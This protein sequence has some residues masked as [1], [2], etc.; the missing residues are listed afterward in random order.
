MQAV[1]TSWKSS[2]ETILMADHGDACANSTTTTTLSDDDIENNARPRSLRTSTRLH[3][4]CCENVFSWISD[5]CGHN[6]ATKS[7]KTDQCQNLKRCLSKSTN[8]SRNGDISSCFSPGDCCENAS[9]RVS[10]LDLSSTVNWMLDKVF[11]PYLVISAILYLV[12]IGSDV[13]LSVRYFVEGEL[14]WG[15]LT[16]LFILIPWNCKDDGELFWGYG[17]S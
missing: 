4:R 10:D 9:Y 11:I 2:F 1:P 14:W 15:T 6:V 12:D 7:I 13:I 17:S 5:K 3:N 8:C 16:T